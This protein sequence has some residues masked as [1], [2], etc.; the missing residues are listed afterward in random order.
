MGYGL[1]ICT[2]GAPI[3]DRPWLRLVWTWNLYSSVYILSRPILVSIIQSE[4]S[5][6]C[7]FSSS[8][9]QFI[10]TDFGNFQIIKFPSRILEGVRS[11]V[12]LVR[13]S[14][15]QSVIDIHQRH[16][17][18]IFIMSSFTSFDN[19]DI[20]YSSFLVMVKLSHL[21]YSTWLYILMDLAVCG[22]MFS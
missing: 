14:L 8:W 1:S 13:Q 4:K 10:V 18:S 2:A 11:V 20:L 6:H 7:I 17:A 15:S 5:L 22:L 3:G 12:S 9:F 21:L 19:F 16:L